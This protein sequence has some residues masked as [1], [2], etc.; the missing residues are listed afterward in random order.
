[1][2]ILQR[3]EQKDKDRK[4]NPELRKALKPKAQAAAN[5]DVEAALNEM[6]DKTMAGIPDLSCKEAT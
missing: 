3:K 1:M 2:K 6:R 5:V 4:V